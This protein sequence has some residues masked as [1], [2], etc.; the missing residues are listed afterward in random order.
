MNY[1]TK[2][3]EEEGPEDK[4][5]PVKDR[6]LDRSYSIISNND[7]EDYEESGSE[8]EKAKETESKKNPKK[9][10]KII[11]IE[12]DSDD[13]EKEQTKNTTEGNQIEVEGKVHIIKKIIHYYDFSSK[14]DSK[15]SGK[16]G[17]Q[18]K[19]NKPKMIM[20]KQEIKENL[21]KILSPRKWLSPTLERTL[22]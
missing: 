17:K 3:N 11:Y 1:G 4:K 5:P 9:T 18:D 12:F 14:D 21:R 2:L 10:K 20:K 6:H 19:N 8:N 13:D 7:L 16:Q 15:S 22:L